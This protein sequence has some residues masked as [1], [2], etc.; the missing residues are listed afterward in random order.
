MMVVEVG[1]PVIVAT[2]PLNLTALLPAVVLKF[3]P[4]MVTEVP[5]GPD[6]GL[7]P[8]IVGDEA[9]ETLKLSTLV[10]VRPST[11]TVIFPV[12]AP[13]G[14]VV[15]IVVDV[16]VPVMTAVAPLNLTML[17]AG[18][19]LKLM[20]VMVTVV[21]TPPLMGS[22]EAIAGAVAS[23]VNNEMSSDTPFDITRSVAPSLLKSP[24]LNAVTKE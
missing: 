16:G 14:T 1:V 12:V 24:L 10:P 8:D 17:F 22:K 5:T 13:L 9:V 2:V 4:V 23:F 11:V 20:P 21:P 6:V 19:V 3:V 7:K 15:T 18:V